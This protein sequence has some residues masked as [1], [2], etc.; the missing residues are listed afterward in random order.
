MLSS[1]RRSPFCT[2]TQRSRRENRSSSTASRRDRRWISGHGRTRTWRRCPRRRRRR[3][4]AQVWLHPL[5]L[6][7]RCRVNSAGASILTCPPPPRPPILLPARSAAHRRAYKSAPLPRAAREAAAPP[8]QECAILRER[9][10]CVRPCLVPAGGHRFPTCLLSTFLESTT[11]AKPTT[12]PPHPPPS[13]RVSALWLY[14]KWRPT[15]Q[16]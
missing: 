9:F 7:S 11:S 8:W 4:A 3:A 14:L 13:L 16:R 1:P 10:C 6:P 5:R 12:F 15:T 2:R